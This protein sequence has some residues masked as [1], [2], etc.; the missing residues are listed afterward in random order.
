MIPLGIRSITI[1][2]P[3]KIADGMALA[4]HAADA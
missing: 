2:A 1:H 3:L 4:R